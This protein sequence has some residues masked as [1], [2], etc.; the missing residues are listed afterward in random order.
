MFHKSNFGSF[1]VN[2]PCDLDGQVPE[3]GDKAEAFRFEDS[4]F[5]E[6]FDDNGDGYD[7]YADEAWQEFVASAVSATERAEANL[8]EGRTENGE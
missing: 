1:G 2:L 8:K 3:E 7:G 5:T 4:N 6:D